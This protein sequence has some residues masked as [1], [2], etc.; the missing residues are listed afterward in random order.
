MDS[1]A[2]TTTEKANAGLDFWMRRA[3]LLRDRVDGGFS[4]EAVHDLRVA[5]RRCRSMANG[6]RAF[7]GHPAWKEMR[8]EGR[9]LFRRLG[10]L[11]DAQI[12]REWLRRLSTPKDAAGSTMD[13]HL[14]GEENRLKESASQAVH[15]FDHKAWRSW[16]RLLAARARRIPP[17]SLAFQHLALELWSEAR[18]LHCQA[19]RNR[20]QAAFHRLRIGLKKFRYTVENFL[21][22]RHEQWGTDLKELQ[23]ALGEMH[24]LYLLWRT[25]LSL[26]AFPCDESRFEWRRKIAEE[27]G[28][29]LELY[30]AKMMGKSSLFHVWRRGLPGPDRLQAA[31]LERIRTWAQFRDPDFAH[32]EH[33]SRLSLQLYDR[34]KALGLFPG[35]ALPDARCLLRA[36]A[37]THDVG[38]SRGRKKHHLA[39]FKMIRSL[40]PLMGCSDE[41]LRKIALIAR[42]HRGALPHP[43]RKGFA[44]ISGNAGRALLLLC[45]ILRLA[46]AFDLDRRRRIRRLELKRQGNTLILMAQGYNPYDA[47]AEKISAARHLLEAAFGLPVLIREAASPIA[48]RETAGKTARTERRENAK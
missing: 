33:V 16:T 5:L 31:V 47:A 12:Q 13:R 40:G 39:S 10:A 22:A 17:E 19:L 18:V 34:L 20:S 23:D 4:P 37:L 28:R 25:A 26:R 14:S 8:D 3:A 6:Y 2:E 24:D 30:R 9:R 36:A 38:I 43:N 15:S 27:Q 1:A 42:S 32:S 7:D 44:G 29:R 35:G 45:G 21:P 48:E 41:A 11:R 46:D